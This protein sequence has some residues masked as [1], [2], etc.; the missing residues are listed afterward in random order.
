MSAVRKVTSALVTE[1]ILSLLSKPIDAV[2][3]FAVIAWGPVWCFV[4]GC[5]LELIFCAGIIYLHGHS[6][7]KGY[8]FTGVNDVRDWIFA[9]VEGSRTHSLISAMWRFFLKSIKWILRRTLGSYWPMVLV[10]SVIYIE[11][12]YV[13]LML[14]KQNETELSLICRVTIPAI[15]WSIG[16]WTLIM[17]GGWEGVSQFF[18]WAQAYFA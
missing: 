4:I 18:M 13:S 12:D 10:G 16:F 15:L 7:R 6:V 14:K 5:I 3:L 11:P 9:P 1:R 2:M 17:W 8:D